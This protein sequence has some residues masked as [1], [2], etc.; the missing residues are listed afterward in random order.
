MQQRMSSIAVIRQQEQA[1]R[2]LVES[3]DWKETPD[4]LR[5]K[6]D[7]RLTPLV[8]THGRDHTAR[9]VQEP[10]AGLVAKQSLAIESNIID[11]RICPIAHACDAT[12][13][14]HSFVDHELLDIASRTE[15]CAGEQFLKSNGALESRCRLVPRS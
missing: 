8:I 9:L 7:D 3:A 5:K 15:A 11:T 4:I 2:L 1:G 6:M 10:V 12:V 14:G 13:H